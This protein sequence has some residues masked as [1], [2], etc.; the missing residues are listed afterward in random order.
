MTAVPVKTGQRVTN[1]TTLSF[2]AG[3]SIVTDGVIPAD[4]TGAVPCPDEPTATPTPSAASGGTTTTTMPE[5][6]ERMSLVALRKAPTLR[7][8]DFGASSSATMTFPR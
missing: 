6:L 2:L 5:M 3:A 8:P 1:A 4:V 7:T